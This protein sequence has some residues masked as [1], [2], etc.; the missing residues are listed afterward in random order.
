MQVAEPSRQ[1]REVR[2]LHDGGVGLAKTVAGHS[3]QQLSVVAPALPPQW[4]LGPGRLA[5]GKALLQEGMAQH[6]LPQTAQEI[7]A[8]E[9][10]GGPLFRDGFDEQG[11]VWRLWR[12]RENRVN[13]ELFYFSLFSSVVSLLFHPI[14]P[15]SLPL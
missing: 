14:P 2:V 8:V 6:L 4:H 12:G 5:Q 1:E 13:L 3:P 11:G 15:G 9:G 7:N 10:A